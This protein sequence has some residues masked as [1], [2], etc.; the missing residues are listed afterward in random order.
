MN[1]VNGNREL[2]KSRSAV[3]VTRHAFKT[4]TKNPSSAQITN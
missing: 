3:V 4:T 1:E 2:S